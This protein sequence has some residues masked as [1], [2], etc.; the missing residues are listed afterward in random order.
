VNGG[1]RAQLAKG[2]FPQKPARHRRHLYKENFALS[3][4]KKISLIWQTGLLLGRGRPDG[5]TL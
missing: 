1:Q 4:D 5:T 3:K 2:Q